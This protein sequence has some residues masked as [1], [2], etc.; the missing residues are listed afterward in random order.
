M[1]LGLR[2]KLNP[3]N[4]VVSNNSNQGKDNGTAFND[5]TMSATRNQHFNGKSRR[6]GNSDTDDELLDMMPLTNQTTSFYQDDSEDDP[7][8]GDR[9]FQVRPT[10]T[11]KSA[12][13]SSHLIQSLDDSIA[14][15]EDYG[16]YDDFHTIDWLRE[17]SR[18]R[19]RHRQIT[20][21]KKESWHLKL[22][23]LH[24][25]WSGWLVVLLV[26]LSAGTCAGIIDIVT[27][28]LSDVKLGVCP[29]KFWLNKESCC[30]N[31]E[32][33]TPS[34]SNCTKWL[35]WSDVFGMSAQNAQGVYAVNYVMYIVVAVILATFAGLLVK[36]FAPYACGSGIPEVKTIL[37]GFIIRGYLGKW[38]LLIKSLAAPLS[39][40]ANLSLGKE[41]PLVHIAAC[42]G[43]IFSYLFPKYGKNEA[44]KR[45]VLSAAAAAGV[46]VAF[47]A[48][49]G[50]VL[51]SLEEVSYYFPMKTLW[52]SFFCALTA[53]FVLR[54]MNP[55]GNSHLVMFYV[56]YNKPWFLFEL[57]PFALVGVLGGL[58]GAAFIHANLRWCKFRSTSKLGK[59]PIL[60]VLV[61]TIITAAASYPNPFTKVD[62]SA[63]IAELVQECTPVSKL[64]DP[65]LCDYEELPVNQTYSV[66]HGH[67]L[68]P[69]GEGLRTAI[70]Q[71]AVALIFKAV[72]TV[73]T[74][75]V[76]LPTGLFIPSM[77]VGAIMGR[78][79]GIGMEQLVYAYPD[80]VLWASSCS[81]NTIRESCVTPGLYA[82]VGAA[83]AL[84]GVTRMTVSLVVIMFELTGGL[85]YI[86]PL[87]A[88]A[89][90]SKWAGD[91]FGNEGIYD[92]HI[93]LNGYPFLDNKEE[94]THTTL[95]TDVMMPRRGDPPL[96][97][98]LQE[99]MTVGDL[100]HLV[101]TTT[102]NG[103][104][105][106]TSQDSYRLLGYIYRRDL[107]VALEN[108]RHHSE[109][110]LSNSKAY[111]TLHA[112]T[113][114]TSG[115][116]EPAP[117]RLF[118]V[119]DLSP[120]T[121]TDHTPMEIVVEIFTK[122]GIRQ[123]LVTHNGRLLGII[124]KKDVLRHIARLNKQ[125]PDSIMFN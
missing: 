87:M 75:G 112:P 97:V 42:C 18:N 38:T 88:A 85:Q 114:S 26:G 25:A 94:F 3:K 83:A 53:A 30:W 35:A 74:F 24:D 32:T 113:L 44:K 89:M 17:M 7:L 5:V 91:A 47:G 77:G 46:S 50:G 81:T 84:G 80:C 4:N 1:L 57:V 110:V 118:N 121:V 19:L 93:R 119:V 106:I 66:S 101:K 99:N 22:R 9:S 116:N 69:V 6:K 123:A 109:N 103:F 27:K 82:M 16:T 58:Y 34:G 71:L 62:A 90:F 14:G 21:R 56:K 65:N 20:H 28:W 63:M 125:D 2:G 23:A 12:S 79:I 59:Y 102:Y 78:L 115:V 11:P 40:A 100:E 39:V 52:R 124:T 31:S 48:P 36:V 60:E 49:V 73:F 95:A 8:L 29:E 72:I 13:P 108:A 54:S 64:T 98:V 111:F 122:L 120:I 51:F 68:A 105:V 67:Q 107:M 104:P 33:V 10:Q 70:W 15:M 41:G 76:K 43:N 45:E 61:L 55:Y 37:S 86:V 117:V 92:G 96:K